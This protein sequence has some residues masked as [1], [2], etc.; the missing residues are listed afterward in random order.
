MLTPLLLLKNTIRS[1]LPRSSKQHNLYLLSKENKPLSKIRNRIQSSISL[2]Y[3]HTLFFNIIKNI[4]GIVRHIPP[5]LR[6]S[7]K[8]D[9]FVSA[10]SCSAQHCVCKLFGAGKGLLVGSGV[11]APCG[12][13]GITIAIRFCRE[14]LCCCVATLTLP[15]TTTAVAASTPGPEPPALACNRRVALSASRGV[16]AFVCRVFLCSPVS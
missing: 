1:V 5:Y 2:L 3:P 9:S 13:F 4:F 16:F 14:R 10:T 15:P 8:S 12:Q 11:V 6:L 7:L